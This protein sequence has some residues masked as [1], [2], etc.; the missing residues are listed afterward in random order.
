MSDGQVVIQ[1]GMDTKMFDRQIEETENEL[2]ELEKVYEDTKNMKPFEGQ[3]ED[4]KQL[5]LQMEKVNNKLVSLRQQQQKIAGNDGFKEINK[6]LK[7]TD[8]KMG[9]I[10]KKVGKWTLALFGIR[11]AYS[12]IRRTMSTLTQYNDQLAT[13]LNYINY[14]IAKAL[15]PVIEYIVKLVY[16][17]LGLLNKITKSM[18]GYDLFANSGADAFNKANKNAQK[19]QKTLTGFDE[20]NILGQN[21]QASGGGQPSYNLAD[22]IDTGDLEGLLGNVETTFFEVFNRIKL[23]VQGA[24]REAFGFNPEAIH[25]LETTFEGIRL[26]FQGLFD[27]IDGTMKLIIG[28]LSGDPEAVREGWELMIGGIGE[29]FQGFILQSF[30]W[31]ETLL[32]Y[33]DEFLN[34]VETKFGF[35]GSYVIAPVRNT[36]TT[37]KNLFSGLKTS[38]SDIVGGIIKIFQGDFTGILDIV[39]GVLN[40]IITALNFL[41]DGINM[42]ATPLRLLIVGIGQ[43]LGKNYT[44]ANIKIQP[45][46]QIDLSRSGGSHGG[47]SGR[48]LYTGGIV[49]LGTGGLVN[50]PG[51][52][53]PVGNAIVGE[54]GKEGIIP[55]NNQQAGIIPMTNQQAMEQLGQTIGK[56]ITIN[57]NIVNEMNGR[58][59]SKELKKINTEN[60]FAY[61]R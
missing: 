51:R 20:V 31:K 54:R 28:L 15:E 35:F 38:V 34:G 56:Y 55:I 39:V 18:F 5:G 16:Q 58:V 46:K 8:N 60:N 59:I 13:D 21:T 24:L 3:K 4:L 52:G 41:I 19:L 14:A 33:V 29:V 37:L 22:D 53:V 43:I 57:A 49:T 36:I 40:L 12:L 42:I 50:L 32:G 17:L 26:S 23:N 6:Q 30:G 1:V 7:T 61:N 47:S 9:T 44:L 45:I 48:H 10:L 11:S 2:R 25:G 27:F